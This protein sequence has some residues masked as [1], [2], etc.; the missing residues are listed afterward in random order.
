MQAR[1]ENDFINV[2]NDSNFLIGGIKIQSNFKNSELNIGEKKLNL[3]RKNWTTEIF[4]EGKIILH[5]RTNSF[6]GNTEIL[7]TGQK[8]KGVLGLKWGTKL[9][10]RNSDTL[11]RIR[12]ENQ[13]YHNDKYQIEILNKKVTDLE[14]LL[15]LYGHLVGSKMKTKAVIGFAIISGIFS[16]G[17]L[18]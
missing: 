12:N 16:S 9:T 4:E 13:L 7:E 14:I 5:L 3:S 17:I 6:S 8:I 18:E 10:D 15:T 2:Y 1:L 11:V